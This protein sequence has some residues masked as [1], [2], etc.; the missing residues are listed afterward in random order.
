[1]GNHDHQPPLI[2]LPQIGDQLVLG[3]GVQGRGRL[4]EDEDRFVGDQGPR[5][6]DALFLPHRQFSPCPPQLRIIHLG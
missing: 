4:V 1:M 5:N 2:S 3:L 6:G